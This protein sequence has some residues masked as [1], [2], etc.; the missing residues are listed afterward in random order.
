[1][2]VPNCPSRKK[3]EAQ[4]LATALLFLTPRAVCVIIKHHTTKAVADGEKQIVYNEITK[5]QKGDF[6]MKSYIICKGTEKAKT[7]FYLVLNNAEH[8]LFTQ[9]YRKGVKDYFMNGVTV[10]EALNIGK[11]RFDSASTRTRNFSPT[12]PP[13]CPPLRQSLLPPPRQRQKPKPL[14]SMRTTNNAPTRGTRLH[15]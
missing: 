13:I 4:S 3:E 7:S 8:Y 2:Y 11:A 15:S 10:D 9:N 6:E 12:S 14:P 1:M 5:E